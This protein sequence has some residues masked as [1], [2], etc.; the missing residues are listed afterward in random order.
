MKFHFEIRSPLVL[1]ALVGFQLGNQ[2]SPQ[3]TFDFLTDWD[4]S[5]LN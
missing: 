4:V 3:V 2:T 5:C 1:K